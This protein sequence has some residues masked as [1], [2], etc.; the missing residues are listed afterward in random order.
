MFHKALTDGDIH[1]VQN[2]TVANL[3]ARTALVVTVQD[4]GKMLW[5]QDTDVFYV[6]KNNIGPVWV[7]VL[8]VAGN[9]GTPGAAG[10]PAVF[11]SYATSVER[12]ADAT[13]VAGNLGYLARQVDD[14]SVWILLANTP[15]WASISGLVVTKNSTYAAA[16]TLDT[17]TSQLFNITLAGTLTL[18]LSN[19]LDGQLV[20]VRL[21]QDAAGSRTLI[22]GASIRASTD[23]P[24]AAISST[25][26]KTDYLGFRF[27]AVV[28]KFDY[29]GLIKGF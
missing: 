4:L 18:N 14:G 12:L 10:S 26:G 28:A 5:Q 21:T 2:W 11:K 25:P 16:V 20:I 22:F 17:R 19:G 23:L 7:A 6:L 3:A 29:V 1:K 8:G 24:T 27:N 13:T 9:P 15:V